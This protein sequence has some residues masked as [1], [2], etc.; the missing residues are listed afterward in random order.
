M[1]LYLIYIRI[2]YFNNNNNEINTI[3][4]DVHAHQRVLSKLYHS[5]LID[6]LKLFFYIYCDKFIICITD[7]ELS[8]IISKIDDC[9]VWSLYTRYMKYN[10]YEVRLYIHK[11]TIKKLGILNFLS[12]IYYEYRLLTCIFIFYIIIYITIIYS[13]YLTLNKNLKN[14]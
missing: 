10:G 11:T 1:Q 3:E 5:V 13:M 9:A 6:V 12:Y 4:E 14:R 2:F 8:S 7:K